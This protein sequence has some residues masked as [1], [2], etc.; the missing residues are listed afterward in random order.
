MLPMHKTSRHTHTYT[1]SKDTHTFQMH[2]SEQ[3]ESF[4]VTVLRNKQCF[5]LCIPKLILVLIN[6]QNV[7]IELSGS[8]DYHKHI[9]SI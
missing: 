1:H 3:M 9:T 4:W 2:K 6:A 7:I 8:P 5:C